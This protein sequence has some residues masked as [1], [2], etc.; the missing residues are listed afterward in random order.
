MCIR[1]RFSGQRLRFYVLPNAGIWS[2]W[3]DQ[4]AT[5]K[6]LAQPK[7]RGSACSQQITHLRFVAHRRV[8]PHIERQ[9]KSDGKLE[10]EHA[11]GRLDF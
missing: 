9:H 10:P 5:R 1:D 4:K 3:F 6:R 2:K 8:R 7:V 11:L